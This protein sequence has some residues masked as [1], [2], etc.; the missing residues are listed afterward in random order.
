MTRNCCLPCWG[1]SGAQSSGSTSRP[2]W[3]SLKESRAKHLAPAWLPEMLAGNHVRKWTA[4]GAPLR[5]SVGFTPYPFLLPDIPQGSGAILHWP[6]HGCW[7]LR[8]SWTKDL[9]PFSLSSTPGHFKGVA[10]DLRLVLDEWRARVAELHLPKFRNE[11][12]SSPRQIYNQGWGLSPPSPVIQ[13]GHRSHHHSSL[14][15]NGD[16]SCRRGYGNVF[17]VRGH[18]NSLSAWQARR[19]LRSD[20]YTMER[21]G[22]WMHATLRVSGMSSTRPHPTLLLFLRTSRYFM[23]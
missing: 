23:H 10:S 22:C 9:C 19:W 12:F 6:G 8:L 3:C 21:R 4:L 2:H 7:N 20:H 5:I 18:C 1:D 15:E 13:S 17:E 16:S 14:R 11:R